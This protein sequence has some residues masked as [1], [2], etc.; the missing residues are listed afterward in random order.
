MERP[1]AAAVKTVLP[2]V[3]WAA[4][5]Y[6]TDEAL[7]P[8]VEMANEYVEAVTGR[9]LDASMP[10]SLDTLALQ[11]V[12]LRTAQLTYM[13]SADMIE[14]G[15]DAGIQSFTVPGYSE[16]RREP[17]SWWKAGYVNPWAALDELLWLLM[18]PEKRD[19][20]EEN[21]SEDGIPTPAFEVTAVDWGAGTTE[22]E[23]DTWIDERGYWIRRGW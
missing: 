21:M 22:R 18:T 19:E 20:W 12:A 9:P 7:G 17:T 5:G 4:L 23:A 15:A 2:M 3:D 8:V 13:F 14:S 16:T 6:P 10:S 1:D 11:A